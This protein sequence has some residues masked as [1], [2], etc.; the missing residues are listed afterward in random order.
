VAPGS[1]RA[2]V[3]APFASVDPGRCR[4][5]AHRR[6]RERRWRRWRRWDIRAIPR[7]PPRRFGLKC[8]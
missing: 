4:P 6:Q 8:V 7:A 5:Q 1:P 2:D 3:D